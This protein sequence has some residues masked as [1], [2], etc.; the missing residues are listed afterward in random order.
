MS[1]RVTHMLDVMQPHEVLSS[2]RIATR[3]GGAQNPPVITRG[4]GIGLRPLVYA[5]FRCADVRRHLAARRPAAD[6]VLDR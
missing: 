3:G 1:C 6:N 2:Q 4:D 5:F